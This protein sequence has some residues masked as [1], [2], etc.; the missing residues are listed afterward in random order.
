MM[1]RKGGG[2]KGEGAKRS[3]QGENLHASRITEQ[4]ERNE[5]GKRERRLLPNEKK[6]KKRYRDSVK[7]KS[8]GGQGVFKEGHSRRD[9]IK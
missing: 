5:K 7:N 8:A 3:S 1:Q 9:I 6:K 2:G 4:G